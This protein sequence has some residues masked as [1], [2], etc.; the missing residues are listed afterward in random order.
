M[1]RLPEFNEAADRAKMFDNLRPEVV[2][3][4]VTLAD[5]LHLFHHPVEVVIGYV[6][7]SYDIEFVTDSAYR[8]TRRNDWRP[9]IR[10]FALQSWPSPSKT[11][12][13]KRSS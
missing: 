4:A 8:A 13:L 6:D 3:F 2:T 11:A 9:R 10:E 7:F 12:T 5:R 1:N